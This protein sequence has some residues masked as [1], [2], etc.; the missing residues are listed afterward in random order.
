MYTT[1]TYLT[2]TGSHIFGALLSEGSSYQK[3]T[4]YFYDQTNGRLQAVTYPDGNGVSYSYDAIGNLIST[5]PAKLV[6]TGTSY[7]YNEDASGTS[8]EYDYHPV[9]QRLTEIQ[10]ATT[11]YHFLYDT[12]GN[13]TEISAGDR[14]LADYSYNPNNGKLN[15]LTYGNGLKVKYEYDALDRV[16]KVQYNIGENEAFETVYTYEYNSAGRLLSVTDH[17]SNEVM[18]CQYDSAGR[19]LKTYTYDSKT[20]L[21]QS[22]VLISYDEQSR[23]SE[24]SYY[25][26]Y[27]YAGNQLQNNELY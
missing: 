19:L 24:K 14:T 15:T 8:V 11:T 2:D 7:S 4:R 23:V 21:N 18:V 9:N 6:T 25:L 22:G 27:K 13:T 16:S 17:T 1:K 12:F 5:L 26:D 20:H 10:T 3:D